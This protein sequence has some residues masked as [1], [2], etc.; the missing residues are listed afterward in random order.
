LGT[1]VERGQPCIVEGCG[2]SDAAA[3]YEDDQGIRYQI[4]FSGNCPKHGKATYLGNDAPLPKTGKKKDDRSKE[5]KLKEQLIEYSKGQ[6]SEW[7]VRKLSEKAMAHY[8]VKFIDGREVFMYPYF[9]EDRELV[10]LKC[11]DMN[12]KDFWSYGMSPAKLLFGRESFNPGGKYVTITEGENDA[13]AVYDMFGRKYPAVSIANGAGS[14]LA[15]CKANYEWLNSFDNIIISFDADDEGQKAAKEVAQLFGGKSKIV[16]LDPKLKDANGYLMEGKTDAYIKQWWAAEEYVPDGIVNGSSLWDRINKP[17]AKPICDWP[18]DGMN[19]K[20]Y[21][22]YPRRVYT[23]T[24]GSGVGKTQ[25]VR[26]VTYHIFNRKPDINIG[27]LMLE[28]ATEESGIGFMS[29]YLNKPLHVPTVTYT[30]EEYREAF[31]KTTG[32][33][34]MYFH[35]HFGSTSINNILERVR[36]LAKVCNCQ[37]VVLDHLSIIVSAQ[38]EADERKAIDEIMTKLRMLVQETGIT[39]FLVSHLRR[40]PGKNYTEGAQVSAGDLRGSAAIEQ[41]SDCIIGLERNG[42]S[43]DYRVANTT[44]VRIVKSRQFGQLGLTNGMFYDKLTGRMTQAD[45]VDTTPDDTE[46]AL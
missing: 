19:E 32:S 39:L 46:D 20:L 2:S 13:I 42:Q 9:N 24:A 11:R 44:N 6:Y 45:L 28:E 18:L 40:V 27:I 7:G 33:G 10:A 37:V 35:D 14:A 26:E 43:E 21:G 29:L 23:I 22:V 1:L 41:L 15:C 5:D 30:P 12:K 34:R 17:M 31:E 25:F 38:Q 36:Y 8:G 16:K 3:I 4:C